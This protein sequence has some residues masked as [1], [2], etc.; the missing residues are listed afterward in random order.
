MW[1]GPSDIRYAAFETMLDLLHIHV[2]IPSGLM[3]LQPEHLTRHC[4]ARDP[5][6]IPCVLSSITV[7]ADT[8]KSDTFDT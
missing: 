1:C 5:E 7:L 8:G 3:R 4:A 2:H 6:R